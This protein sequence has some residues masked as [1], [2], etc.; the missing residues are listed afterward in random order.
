M[1]FGEDVSI[2]EHSLQTAMLAAEA[3]ADRSLVVAALLHDVGH[4]LHDLGEDVAARG[5][6]ARHE[7]AGEAWLRSRFGAEVSEPV[8]LHVAAKRYLCAVDAGYFGELSA[9]SRLS[10]ELQGGVFSEAEVREFERN[11][12][13]RDAVRLRRWDDAAKDVEVLAPA[14]ETYRVAIK[15]VAR[16]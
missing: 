6:D 2:L 13:F 10:L 12:Y 5:I 1:Y 3:G 16:G 4:L 9:S 8:R 11:P 15:L 14:L 7:I